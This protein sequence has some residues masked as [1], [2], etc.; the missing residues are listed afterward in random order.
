MV[1]S[2]HRLVDS[3][4]GFDPASAVIDA[5]DFII[6]NPQASTALFSLEVLENDLVL[7]YTA[8]FPGDANLDGIVDAADLNVVGISWQTEVGAEPGRDAALP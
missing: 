6:Q 8:R 3:V 1:A 4:I 2:G 7:T 5:T